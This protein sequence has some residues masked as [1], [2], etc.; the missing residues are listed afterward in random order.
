MPGVLTRVE[1][2]P[3]EG[4][5]LDGTPVEE[6]AASAVRESEAVSYLARKIAAAEGLE[7]RTAEWCERTIALEDEARAWVKD[8]YA[9][10]EAR[11]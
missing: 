7:P 10:A 8:A 5:M 3:A 1:T 9:K 2:T 11:S 6:W 4:W